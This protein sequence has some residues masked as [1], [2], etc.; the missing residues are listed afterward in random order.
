VTQRV[1]FAAALGAVVAGCVLVACSA[2][3]SP[4]YDAA[5]SADTSQSSEVAVVPV[6]EPT[7][8]TIPKIG[9]RSDIIPL[10]L[11]VDGSLQVPPVDD[12]LQ[13]GWWAGPKPGVAGEPGEVRPG[14]RGSA[15]VAAHVDGVIN[16]RKGQPGLF[17][18]LHELV[19]GDEVF[20]DQVDGGQLRFL[21]ARVEQHDKD[22]FPTAAVYE[23]SDASR[24][25]LVTCTGS[26]DRAAGHYRS[27]LI[28]FTTLAPEQL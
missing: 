7:A 25:N 21:V 12:P 1:L 14:E 11:N 6:A 27:N 9:A 8:I 18:R 26:F 22:K 15:V 23:A 13:A 3:G 17:A 5:P 4:L 16:G 20:V 19:P 10:G 24:L 2:E 28:V